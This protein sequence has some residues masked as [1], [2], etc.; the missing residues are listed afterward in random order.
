[1]KGLDACFIVAAGKY[2]GEDV[3]WKFISD[4]VTFPEAVALIETV[5]DYPIRQIE[6]QGYIIHSWER[7]ED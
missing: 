6:C 4:D 5:K 1:M 2:D 3:N 7:I